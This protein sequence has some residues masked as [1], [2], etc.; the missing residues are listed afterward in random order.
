M[1]FNNQ[2]EDDERD[3]FD[4]P[5]VDD[6]KEE[7]REPKFRP[8]QPEYYDREESQWEHLKPSRGRRFWLYLLAGAVV[9]A[10]VVA[11][12]LRYFAAYSTDGTMYGYVE[13]IE[14]RGT[15]FKTDEGVL[16]P[17][18]E[19]ADTTRVYR[20]DFIFTAANPTIGAQLKRWQIE[21]R[22][23]RVQYDTYHA[24]VPWRGESR[25]VITRVDTTDPSRILPPEFTPEYFRERRDRTDTLDARA[26][27]DRIDNLEE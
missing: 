15:I 22:P 2:D 6:H 18:K 25:I 23:V 9:V 14:T 4:G 8:D 26:V 1:K 19:L 16:I 10:I 7:R 21:A 11:V 12:W 13:S 5:D 17:F 24:T 20:R 3:W 27:Q